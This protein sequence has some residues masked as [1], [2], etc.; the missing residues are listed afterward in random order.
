MQVVVAEKPSVARDIA[1]VLGATVRAEGYFQGA[2]YAVTWAIGHLVTL[3]EPHEVNPRWKRWSAEALPMLP[4]HW[5]LTVI[6]KTRA[7]FDAVARLLNARETESVV[8]ATDAGRE[9][10]LIFRH[11]VE[12][13]GCTKPVKRLWISSLTPD[14]IRT[15]FHNLRDGHEYDALA[16]AAWGRSC[17]DWLVGMNLSRAYTLA[18]HDTL[19]V[20]RVQTPTL[21][22]IVRR[23]AEIRAFVPEAYREVW[24]RLPNAPH[25]FEAR[26]MAQGPERPARKG[27]ATLTTRAAR[28]PADGVLAERV[29]ARAKGAE[30]AVVHLEVGPGRQAAPLLYDL[31]ELQRHANRLFGW[32]AQHTLDLAQTLY[33]K[34][35][36]ISYPRTDSQH[37]SSDIAK[38]LPSVVAAIAVPYRE[39]L[40]ASCGEE[41]LGK[42]YVDDTRVT[43]HH[44]IIPTTTPSKLR[45]GTDE[46]RLYDLI[47]RRLLAAYL[48]DYSF[49][50]TTLWLKN[51]YAATASALAGE[52]FFRAHG[53]VVK[54]EGH[55]VLDLR[56]ARRSG[57]SDNAAQAG[58]PDLKSGERVPVLDAGSDAKQTTPPRPLDDASLLTA[59]ET[60]GRSLEDKELS[61]AM[62]E[63]GL[64]TPATRAATIENLLTRGYV[65]REGKQLNAT[66]KGERLI[67][68]VHERVRS[69]AMTGDWEYQLKQIERGKAELS[70]FIAAVES[71]VREVVAQVAQ[72]GGNTAA[73]AAPVPRPRPSVAAGTAALAS[74]LRDVF[75]HDTFRP[76][77]Q[78]V[79]ERIARGEHVLLVMPTGAGKS[80]CYQLPGLLR[81]GTTLVISPLI[82]LMEDQVQKLKALGLR[83]DR[84]HS[85]RDR[86]DSRAVCRAYLAAELDFLFIAPERLGVE[87]FPAML[88]KRPP[89]LIAIDEAHCISHWGHDF[90]PDYRMLKERLPLLGAAPIV[91]LTA[92]ATLRVQDDIVAQLGVESAGKP[93]GKPA[94]RVHRSIHGFRRD[95]LAIEIA[96]V[97][98]S[99][100]PALVER[101]LRG[102]GRLP[103]IVYASSRKQAET[104]AVQLGRKLRTR[105]YHAGMNAEDRDLAQSSFLTGGL[106]VIVATVAF[107]MGVD[108]ADVRTVIHMALPGSVE[109]YYQEIGRAGRDGKDAVALLLHSFQD[110]R[111]HEHFIERDYPPETELARIYKQ[112]SDVPRLRNGLDVP[113]SWDEPQIDRVLHQLW[114]HGGAVVGAAG[115]ITRGH[116]SWRKPYAEQQVHRQQQ[117]EHIAA[118]ARGTQCRMLQLVQHFGDQADH[119]KPCGYCD[120][121]DPKAAMALPSRTPNAREAE[122]L[123]GILK[124]LETRQPA[125]G[126]LYRGALEAMMSRAEFE[127]M[128]AALCAAGYCK[129]L[130]DSFERDGKTIEFRRLARG[131]VW[132]DRLAPS[133]ETLSAIVQLREAIA[134]TVE[135]K[136]RNRK[137]ASKKYAYAKKRKARPKAVRKRKS[138]R[139]S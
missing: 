103:A 137:R 4:T 2:G 48:P 90:R 133:A 61:E 70:T 58:L 95:N 113:R 71:Y 136:A 91:A 85:G 86:I 41:P 52:D 120:V 49:T 119:G 118:Y 87:G 24:V 63:R 125:L 114:I 42:R 104:I 72:G 73:S 98:Q 9:G 11:I 66:P 56:T 121:C 27:G 134:P 40:P 20:G 77:Q 101:V 138:A 108:K 139:G 68:V 74:T 93:A 117:L 28:L 127:A 23:A 76:H 51:A 25:T 94:A 34:H 31:T 17:A 39:H 112:L 75:G 26:Y 10:E 32:S 79:C 78:A 43:D 6:E 83:A 130:D 36:L 81:G 53:L 62:R 12:R 18:F 69:A 21:A 82:A 65:V 64:G 109:G 97:P 13:S 33:E 116:A 106:D 30:L 88:G 46:Q 132:T 100:R 80:L 110:R 89:T 111:A 14:A 47:C 122:Q 96:E 45:A 19:T 126:E 57:P 7:Q 15:G 1:K 102:K 84:I 92:T 60:A 124:A 67:D 38:Q 123:S 54:D 44:A 29:V 128:V 131:A 35:K 50:D 22:M 55:R 129:L 3:P 105:A 99:A 37:L 135:P 115:G 16:N 107:G 8:C 5:P 59:M